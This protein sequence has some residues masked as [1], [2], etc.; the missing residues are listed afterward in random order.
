VDAPTVSGLAAQTGWSE[1]RNMLA[2]LT[3]PA[4]QLLL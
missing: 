4:R 1:R 2:E 3:T